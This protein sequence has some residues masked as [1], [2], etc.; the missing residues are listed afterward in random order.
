MP[1]T[2]GRPPGDSSGSSRGSAGEIRGEGGGTVCSSSLGEWSR[3]SKD[4]LALSQTLLCIPATPDT[5]DP[6]SVSS[7]AFR[8]SAEMQ[9]LLSWYFRGNVC[10]MQTDRALDTSPTV[11]P[12]A[13]EFWAV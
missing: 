6:L 3:D 5:L 1:Y 9:K 10:N 2:A 13:G 12:T 8:A 11:L 4:T 7:G